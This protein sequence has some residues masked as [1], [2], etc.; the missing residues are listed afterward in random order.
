MMRRTIL[1]A[2]LLLAV[3]MAA[4][5]KNDLLDQGRQLLGSPS[6]GT[7]SPA[8]GSSSLSDSQI[9]G[10]IKEALKKGVEKT[11]KQLSSPG[12][13]LNDKDVHIP[14][15]D[16]LAKLKAPLSMVG[17]GGALADL[18]GKMNKA[19]EAAAP[20]ALDIFADALSKMTM[21]DAKGILE[22][23][24]DAATQY[25]KRTST[26]SIAQAF[27]PIVDQAL[28]EVGAVKAYQGVAAKAAP[29]GGLGGFDLSNYA[30]GKAM[31]G[32]FHYIAAEEASIRANPA[33]RTTD[34]LKQVFGG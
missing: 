6:V 26:E 1:V 15:P 12:G 14:L 11:V 17:A 33:A 2:A 30:V 24:Q 4:Y 29:M 8:A 16:T 23:P 10:G 34:L 18:E 22:G 19:A 25:F 31:D 20:K 7:S 5:A 28:S 13:Y 21:A 27:K 9:S 3:P 32:L